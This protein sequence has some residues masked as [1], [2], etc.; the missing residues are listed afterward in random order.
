MH[1]NS[2]SPVVDRPEE[3]I[4]IAGTP[5][6]AIIMKRSRMLI[7]SLKTQSETLTAKRRLRNTILKLELCGNG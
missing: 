7:G 6:A 2:V 5:L 3:R 1:S 4:V